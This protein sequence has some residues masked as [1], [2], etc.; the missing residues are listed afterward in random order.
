M[1]LITGGLGGLAYKLARML[2][3]KYK[4]HLI[5]LDLVEIPDKKDWSDWRNTHNED[6]FISQKIK[7]IQSLEGLGTEVWYFQAEI[8]QYY[9]LQRINS[10]IEKSGET[11]NGVFHLAGSPDAGMIMTKTIDQIQKVVNPKIKGTQALA[12][13]FS[14]KKLD[15]FI[16]FSSNNSVFGGPG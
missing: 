7:Q 13:I 12:G 8:C 5:L 16:A 15:F 4:A 1:Y 3:E 11:I 2:A 10:L 14:G 6:H 9:Q